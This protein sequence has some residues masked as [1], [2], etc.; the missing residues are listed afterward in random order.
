MEDMKP[1][2][3]NGLI[4]VFMGSQIIHKYDKSWDLLM[5]VI[6]K[7]EDLGFDTE[8]S[9]GNAISNYG[10]Q[11]CTIGKDFSC[12]D[13]DRE[14]VLFNLQEDKLKVVYDAV[15]EFIEWYNK[16]K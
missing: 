16:E 8:I 13:D 9:R 5:P 2:L 14:E 6:K 10:C 15:V 12:G 11:S 4:A 1:I 3:N 7:I